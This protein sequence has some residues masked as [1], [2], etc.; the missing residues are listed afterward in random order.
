MDIVFDRSLSK[1]Y[2][3]TYSKNE[4]IKPVHD[5]YSSP[6]YIAPFNKDVTN[7][8]CPTVLVDVKANNL[9]H[10]APCHVDLSVLFKII[11]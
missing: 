2:R 11:N 6:F 3:K 9:I 8:C 10:D 7:L 5:E 4:I 1:I